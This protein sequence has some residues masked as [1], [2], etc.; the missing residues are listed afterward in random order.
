MIRQQGISRT[1]RRLAAFAD[2]SAARTVG[3][4]ATTFL[5]S[6]AWALSGLYWG[7]DCGRADEAGIGR[8]SAGLTKHQVRTVETSM[9]SAPAKKRA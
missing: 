8:V 7:F 1:G 2:A 5:T 3:K 6:T 9:N 4:G